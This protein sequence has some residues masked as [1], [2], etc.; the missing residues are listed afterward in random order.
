M[1]RRRML[2]RR[3]SSPCAQYEVS[4]DQ[5]SVQM[6]QRST[7]VGEFYRMCPPPVFPSEKLLPASYMD[8]MCAWSKN[9]HRVFPP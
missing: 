3:R 8:I 4:D 5:D 1:P 6:L 2:T 7:Q 9:S